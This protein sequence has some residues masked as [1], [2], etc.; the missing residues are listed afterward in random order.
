MED[1]DLLHERQAEARAGPLRR[2]ERPEHLLARRRL[3]PRTIVLDRDVRHVLYGIDLRVKDDD[4]GEPRAATRLD[5]VSEQVAERLPQQHLVA[6]ERAEFTL[7]RD[8][9]ALRDDVGA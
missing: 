1:D 3:D 9:A 7:D 2:E 4:R 8:V 6:L 5:G